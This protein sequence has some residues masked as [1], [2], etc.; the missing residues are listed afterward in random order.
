MHLR[1]CCAL[2]VVVPALGLGLLAG[3]ADGYVTAGPP[4]P[5]GVIRYFNAAPDQQWAV[6]R[7]VDAWN[8]SGARVRFVAARR[9]RAELLI[10]HFPKVPCTTNAQASVGYQERARIYVFQLDQSS[11][12]CNS[13]MAVQTVAHEL[14]HVLGLGHETRGCAR[15]NPDGGLQGPSLCPQAKRW[16]WRC[17]LLTPDDVAGAV[18]LYGGVV[19]PQRGPLDCDDYVGIRAPT[20]VAVAWTGTPH[21]VRVSFRRPPS[22]A[23]P[24]FLSVQGNTQE[25][26]VAAATANRCDTDARAH[27]REVWRTAPGGMQTMVMALAQGT[28]CLTVWAVDSFGRPSARP[29]VLWVRV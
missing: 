27:P 19:R 2:L 14:G 29:A 5:G 10:E 4:W 7:A 18:A 28:H 3:S 22:V 26:F 8:S 16:Q 13:L 21:E 15:M 1:I 24:A 23:V 11:P 12:Y 20:R 25:S 9:A 17:R 6:Q